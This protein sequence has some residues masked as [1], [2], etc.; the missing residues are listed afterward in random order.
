[1]RLLFS[2]LTAVALGNASLITDTSQIPQPQ[3]VIEFSSLAGQG[4]VFSQG[5]LTFS[6]PTDQRNATFTSTNPDSSTLGDGSYDLGVNGTWGSPQTYAAIDFDLLGGDAYSM[7]FDF[8][9]PVSSATFYMNYRIP[10]QEEIDG[11]IGY[12]DVI[13]SAFGTSGLLESYDLNSAAPISTP[14]G[15]NIGAFRGILRPTPDITSIQLSNAG[16]IVASLTLT[17][18]DITAPVSS[19]PEPETLVLAGLSLVAAICARR[20]S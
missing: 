17:A 15:T 1:M 14:F 5:P 11:G 20:V 10:S 18:P 6:D 7:M 2:L 4:Y 19:V 8:D 12:S 9:Q 13:L 16:A 3:L